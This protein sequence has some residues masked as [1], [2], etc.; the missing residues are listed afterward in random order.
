M[1]FCFIVLCW[2]NIL[3]DQFFDGALFVLGR[4]QCLIISIITEFEGC[5]YKT[6]FLIKLSFALF[7][8][9]IK[10]YYSIA[11]AVNDGDQL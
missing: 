11:T 3:I 10:K 9:Q 6:D 7:S 2:L 4:V 8:I 1:L 5:D